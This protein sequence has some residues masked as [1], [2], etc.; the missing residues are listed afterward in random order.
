L[1]QSADSLVALVNDLLDIS[2]IEDNR[3]ELEEKPFLPADLLVRVEKMLSQ[4]AIEKG[5]QLIV[6]TE[7]A[8]TRLLIGDEQRLFQI[9]L[10]LVSNAVK[11]TSV[12]RVNITCATHDLA[13]GKVGLCIEVTDSGIGIAP[14]NLEV[15]FDKFVQAESSTTLRYG[16][17]GLGLPIA[18]SLA[19][20]MG[21][22]LSVTSTVDVGSTFKLTIPL[23]NGDDVDDATPTSTGVN[24]VS[25]GGEKV[26]LIEDNPANVV[27]AMALLD[28]LGYE[29][30]LVDNGADALTLLETEA[31]DLALMDVQMAGMNGLEATR[32]FREWEA[33]NERPRLPIIAM[34]AFGMAGDRERCLAA[35]MD[36]YLAKPINVDYFEQLLL[37]YSAQ[38]TR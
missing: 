23:T 17:T 4:Q 7:D 10:N 3:F 28:N 38:Q 11:F 9:L 25:H 13:D 19:E 27:V 2:K 5:I 21:G 29:A 22:T 32:L 12:G 14:E 20:R 36:D 24:E 30:R 18:K 31:F 8:C 16:G 1:Q 37:K 35:G 26:L 6:P 34:T 33:V 15:I